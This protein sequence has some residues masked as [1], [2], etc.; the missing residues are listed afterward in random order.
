MPSAFLLPL[1]PRPRETQK[2]R[3]DQSA[4]PQF[5]GPAYSAAMPPRLSSSPRSSASPYACRS[6][7]PEPPQSPLLRDAPPGLPHSV[8]AWPSEHP[9][10]RGVPLCPPP[11]GTRVVLLGPGRHQSPLASPPLVSRCQGWIRSLCRTCSPEHE[12]LVLAHLLCGCNCC[13]GPSGRCLASPLSQTAAACHGTVRS[14]PLPSPSP[15]Q[16]VAAPS[17]P[18]LCAAPAP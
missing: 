18:V 9:L 16:V 14:R 3:G 11:S 5:P 6:R 7:G 10:R 2:L 12:P 13:S 17:Q 4:A 8:P 1:P 15:L